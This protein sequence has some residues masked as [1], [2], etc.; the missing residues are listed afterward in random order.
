MKLGSFCLFIAL[1]SVASQVIDEL[2]QALDL[3]DALDNLSLDSGSTT[4]TCELGYSLNTA[5][6]ACVCNEAN[7][8][9]LTIL[10]DGSQSLDERNFQHTVDLVESLVNSLDLTTAKISLSQFSYQYKEYLSFS[11]SRSEI[12]NAMQTLRKDHLKEST[13]MAPA[14]NAVYRVVLSFR[15]S[16]PVSVYGFSFRFPFPC[17]DTSI[18]FRV[19]FSFPAYI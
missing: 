7:F 4:P 19:R 17:R 14:L 6:N 1:N 18:G 12:N 15:F 2:E 9:L 8:D 13:Y 10:V 3:I 5:I 11:N 16:F